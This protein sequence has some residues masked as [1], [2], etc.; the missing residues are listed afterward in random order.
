MNWLELKLDD[1]PETLRAAL[2]LIDAASDTLDDEEEGL[3]PL[4]VTG[5]HATTQSDSTD[6]PSN[7][8]DRPTKRRRPKQEIAQLQQKIKE[9]ETTLAQLQRTSQ[10]DPLSTL[11]SIELT[12]NSVWKNVAMRQRKHRR[13]AEIENKKLCTMLHA[14]MMVGQQLLHRV[15]YHASKEAPDGNGAQSVPLSSREDELQS[16]DDLFAKCDDVF[17]PDCF[18]DDNPSFHEIRVKNDGTNGTLIDTH[19]GWVVPYPHD[20]VAEALW[21][22]VLHVDNTKICSSIRM[23]VEERDDTCISSFTLSASSKPDSVYASCS[24]TQLARQY[25]TS[26]GAFVIVSVMRGDLLSTTTASQDG[27]TS[28]QEVWIRIQPLKTLDEGESG[29]FT[30]VQINRQVRLSFAAEHSPARKHVVSAIIE[31]LLMQIEDDLVRKQD[32]VERLL[33]STHMAI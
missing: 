4:D 17:A 21:S 14:Q 20:K 6:D 32:A 26:E 13:L 22:K 25:R 10:N 23:D 11:G 3:L 5:D 1:D 29:A 16:L 27:F 24:G 30:Q 12:P 18:Q 9:L 8:G 2:E 15:K 33:L 19:A 7:S 28:L 31:L